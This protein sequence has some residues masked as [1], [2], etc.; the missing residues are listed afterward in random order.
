[1]TDVDWE[2]AYLDGDPEASKHL[3]EAQRA[4]LDELRSLLADDAAWDEP[5][6][7]LEDKIMA[8]LDAEPMEQVSPARVTDLDA[9]RKRRALRTRFAAGAGAVAAMAA[10]FLIGTT[11]SSDS[12][13]SGP[14]P[15]A[16]FALVRTDLA[17]N[18]RGDVSVRSTPS[19]NE[20]DLDVRGLPRAP[21]GSYYQAWVRSPTKGLV[22]IG[23][24][25]TGNGVVR[26][27]SGVDLREYPLL[28]V[29]LEAE[30]GNAASSGRRVLTAKLGQ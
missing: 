29:T 4:E 22:P 25:H 5:P 14:S 20:F 15:D 13:G 3:S 11:V 17:P 12:G 6:A 21:A 7:G 9:A 26:L 30:D 23:T 2:A 24:F 10:A 8:S 19:G 1:M 16:T 27:W 18:V 28:T